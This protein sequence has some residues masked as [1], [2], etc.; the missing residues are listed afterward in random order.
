MRMAHLL[1]PILAGLM[2][3]S[4]GGGDDGN[5]NCSAYIDRQYECEVLPPETKDQLR[6]QNVKICDNWDA[7]YKKDVMVALDACTGVAC[8]EMQACIQAAN[9]LCQADVSAEI[10]G[11]ARH[12][13][14]LRIA[15]RQQGIVASVRDERHQPFT[16][17]RQRIPRT[18]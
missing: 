12:E 4:C 3:V 1:L 11:H 9:Q 15:E 16:C 10:G 2:L 6:D 18:G 5:I 7:H 17:R 13:R 14:C 8:E